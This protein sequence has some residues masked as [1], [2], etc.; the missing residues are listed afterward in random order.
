[1]KNTKSSISPDE[2]LIIDYLYQQ[3]NSQQAA[4][5]EQRLNN[6]KKFA[7]AFKAQQNFEQL[8]PKGMQAKV[9]AEQLNALQWSL[10]RR[11]KSANQS[12]SLLQR[13]K[14]SEWLKASS[15]QFQFVSLSFA[16]VCGFF[17]STQFSVHQVDINGANESLASEA[18]LNYLNNNDYEIVDLNLKHYDPVSQKVN[19]DY[20]LVT[21]TAVSG[22]LSD[23][24]IQNLLAITL[25]NDVS[26]TT[27][28]NLA[29]LMQNYSNSQAI[30]KALSHSL[31]N[32]PNPGVRMAA[33]DSLVELAH[34]ESVKRVLVE[35][36]ANDT[37][38]GIRVSVFNALLANV[39]DK[40]TL[41]QLKQFAS[42]DSNAYIRSAGSKILED[43]QSKN[44]STVY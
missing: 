35:A 26:D 16:F 37:N 31:L 34:Q 5:F 39:N 11:L 15:W 41:T 14:R 24:N 12:V 9:S 42:N 30:Q 43:S 33:A 7:Q 23:P 18:P 21:K 1:M 19:F 2:Q 20:S 4:S 32:D 27:R 29:E 25:Q 6:D 38:P 28:L 10:G 44:N 17:V 22:K 36:F 3:L 8:F 13:L 40:K